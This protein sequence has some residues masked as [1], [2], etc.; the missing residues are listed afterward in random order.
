MDFTIRDLFIHLVKKYGLH[1]PN[2]NKPNDTRVQQAVTSQ[3]WDTLTKEF[4]DILENVVTIKR[5]NLILEFNKWQDHP[6]EIVT[7]YNVICEKIS[8]FKDCAKNDPEFA[9]FLDR[10]SEKLG[11]YSY[12]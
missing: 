9:A 11:T 12:D 6:E 1:L 8:K 4:H 2:P 7:N 10:E 3:T 5:K